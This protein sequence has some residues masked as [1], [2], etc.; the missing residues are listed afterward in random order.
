MIAIS[1][2]NE[3]L[4]PDEPKKKNPLRLPGLRILKT[5]L[6]VFLCLLFYSLVPLP[7]TA[8]VMTALIAVIIFLR[9]IIKESFSVS[10]TRIQS[11]FVGAV[12]GLL[13]LVVKERIGLGDD[14]VP[15]M[16]VLAVFVMLVIWISVSF[17]KETGA[18]LGAIV[19]LAIALGAADPDGPVHLAAAR[20]FDTLIG[21]IIALIV[22]RLL[23]FQ[24]EE[25]L[26]EQG[27]SKQ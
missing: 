16:L 15:Y 21:L 23:P 2:L 17:L 6:A 18:G 12:F 27:E 7:Y 3:I 9:S 14:T 24:V 19:F 5:S 10:F 25:A 11:T 26:D 1:K 13:V 20:F 8:K 22:N 4:T